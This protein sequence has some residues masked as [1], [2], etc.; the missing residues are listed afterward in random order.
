M[1][2]E[3][4]NLLGQKIQT[5]LNKSMPPGSHK[6]EFNGESLASGIYLYKLEAGE[7]TQVKKMVLLR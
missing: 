5:L 4:F 6:V 1:R 2:I 7:F 3:V